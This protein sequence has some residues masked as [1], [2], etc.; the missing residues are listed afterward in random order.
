MSQGAGLREYALETLSIYWPEGKA[1]INS[2]PISAIAVE[3]KNV[4]IPPLMDL[5]SLPAWA[6]DTGVEGTI[7]VPAYLIEKGEGEVWTRV[8]WIG[9]AAWYLSGLP[10]R[11]YER[12]HGPVHSYS[13]RLAKWD[14]RIWERAWVNRIALFLRRWAA[15]HLGQEEMTVCGPLP[16]PRILLTHDVDAVRKTLVIRAKQG[17]FFLFNAARTLSQGKPKKSL[18][19]FFKGLGFIFRKAD[20]W[21]FGTIRSLEEKYGVRSHFNFFGGN[22]PRKGGGCAF[23]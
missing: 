22:G 1:A 19:H 5:V 18:S 23:F 6:A 4:T 11:E 2:L 3:E 12:Q 8:D 10:E 16:E 9:V 15:E 17:A 13:F 14:T 7:L 20:Y 21:C